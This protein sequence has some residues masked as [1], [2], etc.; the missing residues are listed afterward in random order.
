MEEVTFEQ[1]PGK[2]RDIGRGGL[3]GRR[4]SRC[5]DP[6]EEIRSHWMNANMAGVEQARDETKR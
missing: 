2:C 3:P 4:K 6:R 1:R 5:K